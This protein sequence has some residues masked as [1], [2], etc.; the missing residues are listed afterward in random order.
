MTK[1]TIAIISDLHIGATAREYDLQPG[2]RRPTPS[3]RGYLERFQDCVTEY[4]LSADVLIVSG[5]ITNQAQPSQFEH[6]ARVIQRVAEILGVE[7]SHIL[8]VPGNH[9]L[10]WDIANLA[11][12]KG[13]SFWLDFKFAPFGL[14]SAAMGSSEDRGNALIR[15]PHF[16]VHEHPAGDFWCFNSAAYDLPDQKPHRGEMQEAHRVALEEAI[17][18][19]YSTLE[20][21]KLRVFVTHHHVR[22][23]QDLY[24]DIPDWSGMVNGE[25]LL[26]L[27]SSHQFDAVLHGHKHKAWSRTVL[28]SGRDPI[29]LWCSGSFSQTLGPKYYGSVGN[30]WH[31]ME[32][33][34]PNAG[35]Q[36]VGVTRSW[37]FSPAQG[38]QPSRPAEH[39]ID[40][41]TPFGFPTDKQTLKQLCELRLSAALATS[42]YVEWESIRQQEM[43]LKYQP[44]HVV[45]QILKEVCP[46]LS[47]RPHGEV[48]SLE[49]LLVLKV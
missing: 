46:S 49:G 15:P 47:A 11:A 3:Y 41:L 42:S 31:L 39:S 35:G 44:G 30:L 4:S 9:D 26:E 10:N 5:D 7:K 18:L 17:K 24:P 48:G 43:A 25:T 14:G 45:W 38:W 12:D 16:Y 22:A 29:V 27:L 2:G 6:G 23:F 37:A 13:E 21:D 33:E 8:L 28:D 1:L 20:K 19:R 34:L 32:M 36:C 40:H